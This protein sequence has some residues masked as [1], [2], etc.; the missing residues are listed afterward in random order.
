MATI[1]W[2][3]F[4]H[5]R[6]QD[7]TFNPKIRVYHNGTTVYLPTPIFTSFV[8]FR[9]GASSGTITD[10]NV[11]DAL[12]SRVKVMR[13]IVNDFDFVVEGCEDAKAV[14]AFLDRK[15]NQDKTLDFISFLKDIMQEMPEKGTKGM[16]RTLFSNLVRFVGT[17][18]LPV[19]K[20]DSD[21]LRRLASWLKSEN[22][23]TG[24]D[25]RL[26][27]KPLRDSTIQS[28]F[29]ILQRVY[30]KM[31]RKYNDYDTGDIVIPH[32]PFRNFVPDLHVSYQKKAV[33]ADVIRRIAAYEPSRWGTASRLFA[34]DMFLLSF[35]LAGM[36]IM[37]IYTCETYRDGRIDY[38]RTKTREKKQG[39][40]FI[41]V[42]V[43][44]EIADIFDR[45]RDGEGLRVFDL[46]Q[47][48]PT[49][50]IVRAT[51]SNGMKLLSRDLGL[52]PTTF[53]A[54]RH[55]FATIARND[56]DVS[57]DDIALC[58]THRSGY[59][60]TDTYV[61]PDFSRVDRVIRKVLDYVFHS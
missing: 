20:L 3:V 36:N 18:T 1:S 61:R 57:M 60:M 33:A 38:C 10:G 9:R 55:S 19:R 50:H 26:S 42:P 59:D 11:E 8:R 49:I 17:E 31:L 7:G 52:E 51:L 22:R 46:Y 27:S 6:K 13:R 4:K 21:F 16:Y 39:R 25:T 2:V 28:Y 47:R 34:R 35:A 54:A 14:A 24:G 56:C 58:L 12:N 53:Y 29:S 48:F 15:M 32:D 5:H 37:D 44:P 40:A 30:N 43:S 23:Y 45:Y 41:S